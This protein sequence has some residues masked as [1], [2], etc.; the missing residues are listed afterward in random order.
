MNRHQASPPGRRVTTLWEMSYTGLGMRRTVLVGLFCCRI[1]AAHRKA[2]A[3]Q[4]VGDPCVGYGG[5][6]GCGGAYAMELERGS[7]LET[8]TYKSLWVTVSLPF[9]LGS[10]SVSHK[11]EAG[12]SFCFIS[13]ICCSIQRSF[14]LINRIWGFSVK[15]HNFFCIWNRHLPLKQTIHP[16]W[17]AVADMGLYLGQ[18]AE[19]MRFCFF[20]I[21]L[22]WVWR[23]TKYKIVLHPV[24][25][26]PCISTVQGDTDS[27]IRCG[28]GLLPLVS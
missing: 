8:G 5:L 12:G 3:M 20:G 22:C 18:T 6:G 21:L 26:S 4:T 28:H 14:N 2:E 27:A 24:T 9:W 7:C 23:N 17:T 13:S 25:C 16:L 19:F 10:I 11:W 1:V 15:K